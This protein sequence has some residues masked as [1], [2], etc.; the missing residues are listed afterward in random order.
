MQLDLHL[1]N[2]IKESGTELTTAPADRELQLY[3]IENLLDAVYF[4][5]FDQ[6]QL[7]RGAKQLAEVSYVC[8][9][10]SLMPS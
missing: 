7:E 10:H 6:H 4:L 1:C 2:V 5:W 8:I 9:S 3:H